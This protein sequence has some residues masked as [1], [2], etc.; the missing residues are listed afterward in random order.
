MTACKL[1][2]SHKSK[3]T[4]VCFLTPL[5]PPP[6]YT[7]Q[8]HRDSPRLVSRH[9]DWVTCSSSPRGAIGWGQGHPGDLSKQQQ[10]GPTPQ[11]LAQRLWEG[12]GLT[13]GP[14]DPR[15]PPS[16]DL[17]PQGLQPHGQAPGWGQPAR[18]GAGREVRRFRAMWGKV[19]TPYKPA[20]AHSG[21]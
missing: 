19:G 9:Q 21:S 4:P 7:A 15:P 20:G 5:G 3:P 17:C 14:G 2:V 13:R 12:P 8:G 16:E 10:A 1:G 11:L 6:T 18:T